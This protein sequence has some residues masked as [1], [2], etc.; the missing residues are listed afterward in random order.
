MTRLEELK[1]KRNEISYL[2]SLTINNHPTC[3]KCGGVAAVVVDYGRCKCGCDCWSH[4]ECLECGFRGYMNSSGESWQNWD[5][6]RRL[7][8]EIKSLEQEII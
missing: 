2:D 1:K 6:V 3:P 4:P 8:K 7:E 5:E